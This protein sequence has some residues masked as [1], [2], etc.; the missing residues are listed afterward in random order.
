MQGVLHVAFSDDAQASDDSERNLAQGMILLVR[1]RLARR[2]DD[3]F[4]GMNAQ[5]VHILHVAYGHAVVRA[6]P[7]H[8]ILYFLIMLQ[9]FFNENLRGNGERGIGNPAEFGIVFRDA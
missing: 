8:F 4:P 2:H 3:G 6:V 9:V 7:H 1:K 5:R